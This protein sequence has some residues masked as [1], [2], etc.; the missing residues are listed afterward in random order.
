VTLHKDN[1]VL[2]QKT[3]K[4]V[5]VYT[6]T[7]KKNC[8]NS[9]TNSP[10]QV[11][12]YISPRAMEIIKKYKNCSKGGY[13]I[14]IIEDIERK[15]DFD[16]KED[17]D[18]FFRKWERASLRLRNFLRS[19]GKAIHLSFPLTAYVFRRSALTHAVQD[20]VIPTNLLA[21]MA[22]TSVDMLEQHYINHFEVLSDYETKADNAK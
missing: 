18:D 7:K 21:K 20:N 4:Y 22:G 19:V 15:Y 6:P 5:L 3:G 16:K 17:F 9:K 14:P 8:D 12:Q 10:S 1:I 2:E 11:T 13:L